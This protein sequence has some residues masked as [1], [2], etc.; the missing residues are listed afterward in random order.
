DRI[1]DALVEATKSGLF[2]ESKADNTDSDRFLSMTLRLDA[3][4][5]R[6]GGISLTLKPTNEFLIPN[7]TSTFVMTISNRGHR[8]VDIGGATFD[9]QNFHNDAHNVKTPS[10][11][12]PNQTINLSLERKTPSNSQFTVP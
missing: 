4:L 3:A 8:E 7:T 12:A 2:D 6:A 1:L 10:R 11:L 9:P 5:A